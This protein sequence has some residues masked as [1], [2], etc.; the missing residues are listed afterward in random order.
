[1]TRSAFAFPLRNRHLAMAALLLVGIAGI[2]WQSPR[3][4]P[5][6]SAAAPAASDVHL[7]YADARLKL[8]R[9]DLEK[10]LRQNKAA[11]AAQVPESDIRRLQLRVGALE[12]QVEAIRTDPEGK[13]DGGQIARAEAVAVLA[14]EDLRRLE[15][16][17]AASP[18]AV[19]EIDVDRVR[20]KVEIAELRVEL[21]KDPAHQLSVTDRVQIQIDQLTDILIDLLDD[22][23]NR[24]TVAAP[25]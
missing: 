11:G 1:M 22:I 6:P 2:A 7:R 18:I 21:W 4:E 9:L 10:A 20:A 12:R 16:I 23:E 25:P 8:A 17:R 19:A 15:R 13:L 5:G 24:R 3:A 14:R